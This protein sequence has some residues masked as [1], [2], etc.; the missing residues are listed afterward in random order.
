MT[1]QRGLFAVVALVLLGGTGCISCGHRGY[2]LARQ[3]GTSCELPACQRNQV[4]V[5]A[6]SG[7]N[8][9]SVMALD[10]L[11][12]ELNRQGFAKVA[13]GQTIHAWWMA[14]EM[15][16]IREQEPDAVFV[17]VGFESA[18]PVAVR[19][20]EKVAA[21]GLPVGGVV[22]IDSE[23]RTA[24]PIAGIR[25]LAIGN[26]QGMPASETVES[27]VVSDA[28]SYGLA[29]DTR[30]VTAVGRLLTDLAGTVPVPVVA[31]VTQWEYPYAPPMRPPG[32]PARDPD[33]LYM[34][35]PQRI[36]S[37][38]TT[39]TPVPSAVQPASAPVRSAIR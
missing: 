20:A 35:D 14:R 2:H 12:E 28:A 6:M 10:A 22:V 8:P 23:G 29:T 37:R 36:A 1:R 13:T 34:S 32:E 31:E 19:L 24:A 26:V 33:W 5:F 39:P 4:H 18:G 15:R 25:A 17:I 16:R 3:A 38:P 9:I 11:A 27:I 30:T 7:L 21:D